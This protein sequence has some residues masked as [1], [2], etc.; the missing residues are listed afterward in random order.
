MVDELQQHFPGLL[1]D[2]RSVIDKEKDYQSDEVI[3]MAVAL[4]WNRDRSQAPKY[5]IRNQNGSSSCVGQA[6]AKA[7]EAITGT[8]ASAHPQYRRRANFPGLG[9]YL[10]NMLDLVKRLGT[11]TEALDKSQNMT[12]AQMN[13]DIYVQTPLTEPL[14]VCEGFRDIDIIAQ[15]IEQYKHCILTFGTNYQEWAQ[16]T[17]QIVPNSY[18]MFGHAVCATYYYTNERGQ[19]CILIDESWGS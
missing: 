17:P 14:Y 19:K 18:V 9:M 1:E 4:N 11:T 12:E 3:P 10:Q 7:L 16:E 5:S 6:G 13:A 2:T 8:V 15:A